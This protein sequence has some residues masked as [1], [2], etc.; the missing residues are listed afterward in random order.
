MFDL[1]KLNKKDWTYLSNA[2]QIS[3]V[4]KSIELIKEILNNIELDIPVD[5]LEIDIQRVYETLAELVGKTYQD[6]FLDKLFS[7]YCLGK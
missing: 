3:L 2:R 5:M 6:E 4:K 7:K 1:E